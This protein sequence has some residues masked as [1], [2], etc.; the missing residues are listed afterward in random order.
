MSLWERL[1]ERGREIHQLDNLWHLYAVDLDHGKDLA[2]LKFA[3]KDGNK[4]MTAVDR[5]V[6]VKYK[7]LRD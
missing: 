2:E 3:R 1:Q 7:D 6:F 5:V 4:Y